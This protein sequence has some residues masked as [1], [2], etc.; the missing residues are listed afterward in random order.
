MKTLKLIT[1][2][3]AC[4]L[5][6]GSLRANSE[7]SEDSTNVKIGLL[8][9]DDDDVAYQP[10]V[11][12][13]IHLK[14]NRII[15]FQSSAVLPKGS[16]ELSIQ[17]R[18]GKIDGGID[19][20]WGIDNLNSM[21]LGFDYGLTKNLTLGVGRSS[22][23]KTYNTYFKYR[24]IG[25]NSSKFHLTYLADVMVDGRATNDWGLSPF[26]FTHRM[27]FTHSLSASFNLNQALYIG[28]SPTLVHFNLVDQSTDVNDYVVCAAYLRAKVIPKV[29]VTFEG[30]LNFTNSSL[31][32]QNQNPSIGFGVEYYT[33]K[34]VFQLSLSN[35]RGLNEPYVMVSDQAVSAMSQ[36]CLGFNIV[37]RW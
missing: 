13:P 3:L 1:I 21:R 9:L 8:K 33:P 6:F 32:P 28:V 18:F 22:L 2:L 17:H 23:K 19:Q 12:L 24:L 25:K 5:K 26:F 37:R 4:A 10:L 20:L 29:Y 16:F 27:N 30:S 15:N 11:D 14:S 7:S 34:H 35:S 31:V 36:F